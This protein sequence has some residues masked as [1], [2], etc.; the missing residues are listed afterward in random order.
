MSN[1]ATIEDFARMCHSY[2]DCIDYPLHDEDVLCMMDDALVMND[3]SKL[4]Y[5]NNAVYEW[6][7]AHD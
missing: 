6:A 5:M 7:T 2:H 4:D 1:K 3:F